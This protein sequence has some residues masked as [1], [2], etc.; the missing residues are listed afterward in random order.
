MTKL[1]ITTGEPA[2]IGPEVS[3]KAAWKSTAPIILVGDREMLLRQAVQLGL[4]AEPPANISFE[5]VPLGTTVH[6]GVLDVRNSPYVLETLRRAHQICVSST[7]AAVVT[8]PVQKSILSEAGE[9]F[10]GHTEFFE[11][12]AGVK[13]VVMMLTS[14]PRQNALKVALATTHLPLRDVADAITPKRWDAVLCMYH[15]QGLPVLKH[16]GFAEGVNVTLGLPY[17]RTS[18]DHGTALDIAGRGI[19]DARSMTAALELAQTLAGNRDA[20]MA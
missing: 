17:V 20:A 7:D 4:S 10:T 14:S 16:V 18:V 1:V 19:A 5:H 13:R 2:G 8:A 12:L 3:V 6:A 15:D 11:H 9:A